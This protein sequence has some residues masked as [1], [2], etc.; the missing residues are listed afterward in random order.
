V[1]EHVCTENFSKWC[2]MFFPARNLCLRLPPYSCV[3]GRGPTRSDPEVCHGHPYRCRPIDAR[4]PRYARIADY[5]VENGESLRYLSGCRDHGRKACEVK[6]IRGEADAGIGTDLDMG[7]AGNMLL[8][9][10]K[11]C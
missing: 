4:P 2:L 1:P 10:D 7:L 5:R 3:L 8:E 6:L 9:S 11:R